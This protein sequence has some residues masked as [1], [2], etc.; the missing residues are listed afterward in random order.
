MYYQKSEHWV[1]V[2]RYISAPSMAP[3][4]PEFTA[5]RREARELKQGKGS[6]GIEAEKWVG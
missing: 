6:K 5:S 2:S 1:N 3:S 4:G